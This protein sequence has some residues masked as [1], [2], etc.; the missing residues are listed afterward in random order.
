MG[1]E[2]QQREGKRKGPDHEIMMP[3]SDKEFGEVR[4]LV[5]NRFGINLTEQKRGL[6]VGRLQSLLRAKGFASFSDYTQYIAADRTGQALVELVNRISTNYTYFYRE[7][8]HFDFFT[9]TVLPQWTNVLKQGDRRDLRVWSAGCSTGQEP[10]GLVMLMMEFFGGEYPLWDAGVL[11]TDISADA[12][13]SAING[14][15]PAEQIQLLPKTLSTKYFVRSGEGQWRVNERVKKEVTFRLFNL[16]NEKFP[17]KKPFHVVFCRN[18]MIY[19]DA[20]TRENL[21]RKFYENIAPGGYFFIGHSESL[22]RTES[23]FEYVMPAVY[24]RVK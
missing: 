4:T 2:T 11:A 1:G 13:R 17:F 14:V 15:Y 20:R 19:F 6:V 12:L 9:K 5:Y 16:M 22:G 7:N 8:T 18:V 10:Y 23:P 3:I 21:V 24:R